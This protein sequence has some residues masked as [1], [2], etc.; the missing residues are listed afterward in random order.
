LEFHNSPLAEVMSA[1]LLTVTVELTRYTVPVLFNV[2]E[3]KVPAAP[4]AF[5]H[6]HA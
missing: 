1:K 2:T 4:L 6:V 5:V 3:V